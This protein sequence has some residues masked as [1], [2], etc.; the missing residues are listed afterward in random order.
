[1]LIPQQWLRLHT[2]GELSSFL[3]LTEEEKRLVWNRY[4][5]KEKRHK[6]NMIGS[7]IGLSIVKGILESHKCEYGIDS[8]LGEYTTF[9]FKLKK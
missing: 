3:W 8:K 7:G 9:Y 2:G 6:R 4:Y 5:K 1:M